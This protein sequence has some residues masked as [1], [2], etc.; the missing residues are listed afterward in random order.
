MAKEKPE[1]RLA[2]RSF[3]ASVASR[4]QTKALALRTSGLKA[5]GR[6]ESRPCRLRSTILRL[7]ALV[8][9]LHETG[10]AL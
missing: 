9:A 10:E 2:L 7:K 4:L 5:K 6:L 8:Q 1:A 3:F